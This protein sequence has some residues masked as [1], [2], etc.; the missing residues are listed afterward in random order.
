MT[1]YTDSILLLDRKVTV[2]GTNTYLRTNAL[3]NEGLVVN[4]DLKPWRVRLELSNQGINKINSGTL[5]LRLDESQ[6]FIKNTPI[7]VDE[8]AKNKYLIE[9]KI[10]QG[11]INGKT[12]RFFINS[13]SVSTSSPQGSLIVLNLIE[14]QY[15]LKESMTSQRH[16]LVT[17]KSSFE[18]RI[19]EFNN[20]QGGNGVYVLHDNSIDLPNTGNLKQ[21]YLVESPTANHDLL[22]D[23]VDRLANPQ[24][25]GGTFTDYY[26][27]FDPI[28]SSTIQTQISANPEGKFPL[29]VTDIINIDPLSVD[30]SDSME[31]QSQITDNQKFKNHV[32][33]RGHPQGG[34]LPMARTI[35]GSKLLHAKARSEWV[36]GNSYI[37]GDQVKKTWDISA[38]N[39]KVIRFFE[40]I[41]NTS[42]STSPD[43]NTTNWQE[44]FITIPEWESDGRYDQFDIIYYKVYNT[45]K[46]YYAVNNIH[47]ADINTSNT[48]PVTVGTSVWQPLNG[49]M[50][51]R[52]II[53]FV[54]YFTHSPWTKDLQKF[55]SNMAGQG[56][57][58]GGRLYDGDGVNITDFVGLIPDWNL[59]MDSKEK[60]D[61][62]DQYESVSSKFVTRINV[63]SSVT[64]AEKF[65]GQR[66]LLGNMAS[67]TTGNDFYDDW[68][69]QGYT[70][71]KS[72]RIAEYDESRG[73]WRFSKTPITGDN[74]INFDDGAVYMWNGT[75][76]ITGIAS[77]EGR[78]WKFGTGM[79]D[80]PAPFHACRNMYKVKGSEGTPNTGIEARF[81]WYTA[82]EINGIHGDGHTAN[83][84]GSWLSFF[85]PFPHDASVKTNIGSLYG[86]NGASG[87]K[88]SFINTFN[89]DQNSTGG[90]NGWND[91]I[92][93]EDMG[94]I[95][96]LRFRLKAGFFR[97]AMDLSILGQSHAGTGDSG[98]FELLIA[99]FDSI[100]MVFWAVDKFDRVWFHKFKLRRN[101]QWEIV[102]I[103]FSNLGARDT[104]NLYFARWTELA[105]W[106]GYTSTLLDFTLSEKDFTGVSFD[107]RFVKGFGVFYEGSYHEKGIYVGGTSI[108]SDML[109]QGLMQV[110]GFLVDIADRIVQGFNGIS[111]LVSTG[112]VNNFKVDET[113]KSNYIIRQSTLAI[114]D[115]HFV[116]DLMVNSDNSRVQNARTVVEHMGNEE[117]YINAKLF[118]VSRKARLSFFPQQ[119]HLRS[120]GNVSMRLGHRFRIKGDRIPYNPSSYYAY[121]GFTAYTPNSSPVSYNGYSW[122]CIKSNTGV[123]PENNPIFWNC[124]NELICE[125]VKHIID[126]EGYV[127]EVFGK[128]KFITT[129]E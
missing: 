22:T 89:L 47:N 51:D 69:S 30:T 113:L 38:T 50:N 85:F 54:D 114:E 39:K 91:G 67:V 104:N 60:Q 59:T 120:I 36:S 72:W 56:Y 52:S 26:F 53:Q 16:Y 106:W 12:F 93:S 126:H 21:N 14:I 74:I 57:L 25:T 95:S 111:T 87:S 11:T 82:L 55:R 9:C 115:L 19:T 119:W 92:Y 129:G 99:G 118:A 35:Y 7:L 98:N 68:V 103:P 66:F 3:V 33:V 86:G 127:M 58:A 6:T 79:D 94:R 37:I 123:I 13:S 77:T 46:F 61:Y 44:D 100:P 17:P 15:R 5:H 124:L 83:S 125:E 62:T 48:N 2:N 71:N 105:R 102:T 81:A 45:V 84:R 90:T 18:K 80:R 24:V 43:Q 110:G 32:I 8:F 121:D 28:T 65:D 41:V 31:E 117:D 76:W 29:L 101:N 70:G 64:N 23:I 116:K 75:T 1:F 122:Q 108:W 78:G 88:Y 20:E 42:S 73:K 27:D 128:R 109:V 112:N 40:C 63:V 34:S 49:A 96:A 97:D 10:S 107:W 4:G